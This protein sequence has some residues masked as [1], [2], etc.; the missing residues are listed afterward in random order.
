MSIYQEGVIRDL[1]RW[2]REESIALNPDSIQVEELEVEHI[3]DTD[4][5]CEIVTDDDYI[6]RTDS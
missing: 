5:L 3:S 6:T 1:K 4:Y 2:L